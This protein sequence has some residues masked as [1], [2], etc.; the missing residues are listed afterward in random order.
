MT[1]MVE[2]SRQSDPKVASDPARDARGGD[3]SAQLLGWIPRL[4]AMGGPRPCLYGAI[5]RW[6]REIAR[7]LRSGTVSRQDL[8]ARIL[9]LG[10]P[11]LEQTIQGHVFLRP[12]GYAGDFET[13]DAFYTESVAPDPRCARWDRHVQAQAAPRAV[14][15]RKEYFKALVQRQALRNGGRLR[16]LDLGSGPCRDVRECLDENPELDL[17]FTCVDQ[18]ANAIRYGAGVCAAF[19]GRVE[20]VR[21]NAL[22]FRGE[23][24]YDLVWSAGVMDYLDERAAIAFLR[25]AL[26]SARPGGEVVI[27]N[28]SADN[29]TRDLMEVFSRWYLHHRSPR[30][31]LALAEGAGLPL[32]ELRL[33]MESEGINLFLHARKQAQP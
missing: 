26:H 14:R 13:I 28:F 18:D 31:V 1:E 5:D 32:S 25:A 17:R 9:A 2:R 3:P 23:P 30:K 33:G 12:H 21:A 22:R 27:G 10:S 20:F 15:N 11:Y 19:P 4:H 7:G 8:D 24:A 29:P 6:V 16:V